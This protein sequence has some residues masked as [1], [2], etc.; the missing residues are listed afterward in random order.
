M[1]KEENKRQALIPMDEYNKLKEIEEA[2]RLN[3]VWVEIPSRYPYRTINTETRQYWC[4]PSEILDEIKRMADHANKAFDNIEMELAP[5]R[6]E[7]KELKKQNN[8][9]SQELVK[10]RDMSIWSF[11]KLKLNRR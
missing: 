9:I 6:D 7:V 2:I 3:K 10:L 1:N 11:I 4:K 5:L 8:C